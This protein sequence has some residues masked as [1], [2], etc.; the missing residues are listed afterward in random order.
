M[1]EIVAARTGPA[2]CH[3]T[4]R[5]ARRIRAD[6]R[7]RFMKAIHV[8]RSIVFDDRRLRLGLCLFILRIG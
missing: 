7:E 4:C 5:I 1:L 6:P 2:A 3:T 8:I